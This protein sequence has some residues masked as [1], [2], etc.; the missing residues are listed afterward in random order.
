MGGRPN[1]IS[2]LETLGRW[3]WARDEMNPDEFSREIERLKRLFPLGSSDQDWLDFLIYFGGGLLVRDEDVVSIGLFGFSH[4]ISLHILDGEGE[5]L[6]DGY[7]VFCDISLPR[8][9]VKGYTEDTLAVAFGFEATGEREAGVYR[10]IEGGAPTLYCSSF[11]ELVDR[12]VAKD[13]RVLD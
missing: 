8:E 4:D 13:A 5:P 2:P 1:W 10:F 3:I 12:L 6:D 11:R 7:L 9:P